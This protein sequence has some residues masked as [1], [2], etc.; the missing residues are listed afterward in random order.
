MEP[1]WECLLRPRRRNTFRHNMKYI[2]CQTYIYTF[3]YASN[4]YW[5][6]IPCPCELVLFG[7]FVWIWSENFFS[8]R[9][10]IT[11]HGSARATMRRNFGAPYARNVLLFIWSVILLIVLFVKTIRCYLE[12]WFVESF[13]L[14]LFFFS[15]DIADF[16]VTLE[17]IK[18]DI[19]H[20]LFHYLA[21]I[22][23]Y[24]LTF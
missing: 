19:V 18:R 1:I 23:I 7:T 12:S 15:N 14:L 17:L 5:V 24:L 13:V 9:A 16:T 21:V 3:R 20:R 11:S 2:K 4:A 6:T 22:F 8:H 10:Q